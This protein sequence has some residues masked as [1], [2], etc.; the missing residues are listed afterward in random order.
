MS[1]DSDK[2][3]AEGCNADSSGTKDTISEQEVS[4]VAHLSCLHI[5]GEDLAR[6]TKELNSIIGY[7]NSLT[8]YNT[9]TVTEMCHA[10]ST[11]NVF[12]EDEV[13]GSLPTQSA[14]QN[15]PDSVGDYFRVPIVVE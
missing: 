3:G 13:R 8:K 10:S 6:F 7:V 5:E 9:A 2:S 15:A 14:L 4:W 11:V 12:R 1:S